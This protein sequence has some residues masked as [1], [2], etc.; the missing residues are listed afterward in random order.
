MNMMP[1]HLLSQI[2]RQLHLYCREIAFVLGFAFWNGCRRDNLDSI[3]S[4]GVR[5]GEMFGGSAFTVHMMIARSMVCAMI[6]FP[7]G[8]PLDGKAA[9]IDTEGLLWRQLHYTV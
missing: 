5:K 4:S 3:I 1:C 9:K 6:M 7:V 2:F 8:G